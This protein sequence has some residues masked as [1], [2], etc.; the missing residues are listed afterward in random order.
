MPTL[1]PTHQVGKQ[2]LPHTTWHTWM[3][4]CSGP[5][6]EWFL[7]PEPFKSLS[8]FCGSP[9]HEPRLF[10]KLDVLGACFSDAGF[11]SWGCLLG[12][13]ILLLLREKLWVLSFPQ[14]EPPGGGVLMVRMCLSLSYLFPCGPSLLCKKGRHCSDSSRIFW[15]KLFHLQL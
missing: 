11:K 13:S 5:R 8:L 2:L 1:R 14:K 3:A 15:R 6:G 7:A 9:P 12:G 10:S 4:P